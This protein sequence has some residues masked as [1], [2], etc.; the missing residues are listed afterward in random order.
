MAKGYF[1][2]YF[3]AFIFPVLFAAKKKATDFTASAR[4][5][6]LKVLGQQL[7]TTLGLRPGGTT[8]VP[9]HGYGFMRCTRKASAGIFYL[10]KQHFLVRLFI[11]LVI[12]SSFFE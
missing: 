7:K 8:R 4:S 3:P 12:I 11:L 6:S 5:V 10:C 1:Y 9:K 2:F